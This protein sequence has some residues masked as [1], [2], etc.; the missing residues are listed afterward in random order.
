MKFILFI[1]LNIYEKIY[2]EYYNMLS[3]E[4]LITSVLSVIKILISL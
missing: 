1:Y 2:N 4:K 3:K